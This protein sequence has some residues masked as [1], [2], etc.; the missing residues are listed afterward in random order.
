MHFHYN[1]FNKRNVTGAVN[2]MELGLFRGVSTAGVYPEQLFTGRFV[3]F[4]G[5][6]LY[7]TI[8]LGLTI[9]K[10][11]DEILCFVLIESL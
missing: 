4:F 10:E 7:C 8:I 6:V 2:F 5:I 1:N 11:K 3:L 9:S